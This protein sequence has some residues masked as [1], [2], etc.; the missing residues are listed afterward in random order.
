MPRIRM[1]K[2]A[3]GADDGIHTIPYQKDQSYHVGA[4]LAKDF[5]GIGVAVLDST[6][7]TDGEFL[8]SVEPLVDLPDNANPEIQEELGALYPAEVKAHDEAPENKDNNEGEPA[9]EEN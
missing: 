1:L 8:P 3:M 6:E 2:T 7:A 9:D 5:I 4:S